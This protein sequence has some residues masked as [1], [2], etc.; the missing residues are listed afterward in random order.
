MGIPGAHGRH[1]NELSFLDSAQWLRSPMALSNA[2]NGTV[3]W[4]HLHPAF[5]AR[6][7]RARAEQR[8]VRAEPATAMPLR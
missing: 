5:K 8:R 6:R 7:G 2:T 3:P 4:N 1:C